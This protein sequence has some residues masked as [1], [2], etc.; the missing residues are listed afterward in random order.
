MDNQIMKINYKTKRRDMKKLLIIAIALLLVAPLF[1]G[2]ATTQQNDTQPT[3]ITQP[4]GFY[5][6][7]KKEIKRMPWD[8]VKPYLNTPEKVEDYLLKY[9]KIRYKGER[10][11]THDHTQLPQ[12]TLN[13]RTGDCEDY[14]YIVVDALRFHGYNTA[15]FTVEYKLKNGHKNWHVVGAFID[16]KTGRWHYIQ[17]YKGHNLNGKISKPHD[18]LEAMGRSM[19]KKLN[20]KYIRY[21]SETPEELKATDHTRQNK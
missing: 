15:M 10:K 17:G 1:F 11:G 5:D 16:K 20:S 19:A 4:R 18:T 21:Y 6:Y 8:E 14:A 3:D 9:V 7:S 12:E 13:L 2:C